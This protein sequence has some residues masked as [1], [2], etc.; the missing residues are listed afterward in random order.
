MM[1]EEEILPEIYR[2]ARVVQGM[3]NQ[4]QD[5]LVEALIANQSA[6]LNRKSIRSTV[7]EVFSRNKLETSP[8]HET[9][10]SGRLRHRF[11]R[12]KNNS[13]KNNHGKSS[14]SSG[15]DTANTHKTNNANLNNNKDK[16]QGADADRETQETYLPTMGEPFGSN[17]NMECGSTRRCSSSLLASQEIEE[18]SIVSSVEET[19]EG[20]TK[21][22]VRKS[23][24]HKLR[25]FRFKLHKRLR[26]TLTEKYLGSNENVE[27]CLQDMDS[28]PVSYTHLDVYKRQQYFRLLLQRFY[29]MGR[30]KP[31]KWE[32]AE[33]QLKNFPEFADLDDRQL[34]IQIFQEFKP[35][36]IPQHPVAPPNNP[37]K[38]HLTPVELDY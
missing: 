18:L 9:K 37:R 19:T 8:L 27:R 6:T 5:T 15:N 23:K 35:N 25:G 31:E 3:Y 4:S 33:E 16:V 11:R 28:I 22:S 36:Q 30:P 29:G 1:R 32:D 17:E 34:K 14:G 12:W 2:N 21:R 7:R 26:P 20:K 24:M 10:L 13:D 38:R